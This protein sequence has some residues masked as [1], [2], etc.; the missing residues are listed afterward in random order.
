MKKVTD[1][2]MATIR[3]TW[4]AAMLPLSK[5]HQVQAL[6]AEAQAF[7]THMS[8]AH[9][10]FGVILRYECP[11]VSVVDPRAQKIFDATALD[12]S[13]ASKWVAEVRNSLNADS[14]ALAADAVPP[15]EWLRIKGESNGHT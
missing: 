4:A 14:T 3:F 10:R 6:L 7:E 1:E 13:E 11:D 15:E 9:Q 12:K 5:A 2:P 8:A